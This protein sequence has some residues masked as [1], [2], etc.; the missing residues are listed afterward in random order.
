M[1][2]RALL[3][4]LVI[5]IGTIPAFAGLTLLT[6]PSGATHVN[7]LVT[8]GSFETGAPTP[9]GSKYY[10]ATGTTLTSF[11]FSVP[12]G[13]QSAGTQSTYAT[14]G[15]DGPGT[16]HTQFS[17]VLPDGANA[18][19][20]GNSDTAV[21]Q[22]PGWNSDGTVSFTGDPTFTP[23]YGGP[24]RLWQTV[25]TDT[26]VAP[27]YL[28]SFWASGE[29]A[30]NSAFAIDSVFGLKVTNVLSGDPIQYLT[31]PGGNGLVGK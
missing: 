3:G 16:P 21:D 5:C 10:W 20:F 23:S 27:S 4:V 28:L 22:S 25:N 31:A 12:T 15:N 14:W 29:A 6:G 7:N 1:F 30:L 2:A 13:W 8:N 26:F 19:Y 24:C 18:V 11:P 9:A 17:D